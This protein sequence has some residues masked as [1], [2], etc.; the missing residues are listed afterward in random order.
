M[1]AI[2]IVATPKSASANSYITRANAQS[3][4]DAR[5]YVDAWT[6]AA[7]TDKDKALA[8]ATTRLDQEKWLGLPKTTTQALKWPRSGVENADYEDGGGGVSG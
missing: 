1:A 6:D 2:T 7:N 8:A 4:F 5:L 3:Y